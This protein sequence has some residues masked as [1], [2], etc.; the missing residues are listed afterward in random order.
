MKPLSNKLNGI[1]ASMTLA[2]NDKAKAMQRAGLDVIALAGGDPDFDTPDHIVAAAVSALHNGYTHY[3]APMVGLP[4][5][6]EA[7]AHKMRHEN[8]IPIDDPRHQIIVTPGGKWGLYLALAAITNPGD[9]VLILEPYWVSYPPMVTLTGGTPVF[10]S[11][12]SEDNF[13][14]TAERLR[15]KVTPRT[16]AIMVN[17]PCNPTGRVLTVEERD[18]IAEVAQEAD[19]YVIADEIY[20][21]LVFDGRSHLSL[22]AAPG[23]AERTLTVNGLTKSYAMT[24]WRLGWLVGPPGII[25]LAT[26]QNGQSVSCAATF[27][28]HAC[29]AALTGP[30]DNIAMM[31]DAYQ[32]RRD[33]MVNALNRIDG[34]ECR[35]IEG[36][37][38]LFPRFPKSQKNSLELADALLEHAQIAATPGIA[39]GQSG[40]G[41]LRFAISTALDDLERAAERL[42]KVAPF[43]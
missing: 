1:P 7:I 40:E 22:A 16:K 20:E 36:A 26:K 35:S 6:L 34:V 32:Q 21:K 37:F 41:H 25:R 33:F 9:E 11:L 23:M 42:A 17:N 2:V 24:G 29:V 39:F 8:N 12:P 5:T 28:M 13:R 27:T 15:A 30:Q 10:V 14:I 31:R 43:L 18:A 3:P 4:Q 19:L 38:Y